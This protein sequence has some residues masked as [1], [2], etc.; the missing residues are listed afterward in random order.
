MPSRT[1]GFS[2]SSLRYRKWEGNFVE[3]VLRAVHSTTTVGKGCESLWGE[4][5]TMVTLDAVG[6]HGRLSKYVSGDFGTKGGYT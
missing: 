1:I 2:V 5:G 4:V 6:E 3:S